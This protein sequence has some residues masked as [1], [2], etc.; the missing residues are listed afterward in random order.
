MEENSGASEKASAAVDKV[1]GGIK[2]GAKFLWSKIPLPLKLKILGGV[3]ALLLIILAVA[4]LVSYIDEI[5][6][7]DVREEVLNKAQ[8]QFKER[9]EKAYKEIQSNAGVK[10]DRAALASTILY[11]GDYD[12]LY[13][14]ENFG[15]EELLEGEGLNLFELGINNAIQF[16]DENFNTGIT[17]SGKELKKFRTSYKTIYNYGIAMINPDEKKLDLE[18]YK[19]NLEKSIV[20]KI[21]SDLLKKE[22][23]AYASA[24][25]AQE[26][27]D[28]A[29]VYRPWFED[30][31]KNSCSNGDSCTYEV[32]GKTVSNLKVRLLDKDGKP[33]ADEELVDFEKY[34]LGVTYAENYNGPGSPI[35]GLKAQAIAARGYSL[36]RARIMGGVGGIKLEEEN[37]EWIL[38]IRN[39]TGDQV[40]C[41]PDQGCSKPSGQ[42]MHGLTKTGVNLGGGYEEYKPPL[43]EESDLRQAFKETTGIVPLDT[44]GAV[45]YTQY[46]QKDQDAFN[47]MAKGGMEA[48]EIIIKHYANGY[49]GDTSETKLASSM[50]EPNCVGGSGS[51][52]TCSDGLSG[53]YGNFKEWKQGGTSP[54]KDDLIGSE[55]IGKVG[56]AATSV[57]IQLARSG[58][59]TGIDP[60]H[61]GTFVAKMKTVGGFMGNN[62]VWDAV[63]KFAPDFKMNNIYDLSG[64]AQAKAQFLGTKI[65]EG[66][67]LILAVKTNYGH[68]VAVDKVESGKI[69]IMDPGG[70]RTTVDEYASDFGWGAINRAV[71]YK[72]PSN[73]VN[74][75]LSN[76]FIN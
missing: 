23:G 1:A 35:E 46:R 21:Y 72:T 32:D 10:V 14:E 67:Y 19:E 57:A 24:R 41:D 45:L 63:Q 25:I 18:Y 52:G 60:L 48:T 16:L 30:D 7:K 50:S 75:T 42:K 22:Q 55:T 65:N 4:A 20:P 12:S 28:L 44:N 62:I 69:Y 64:D 40:Y 31:E 15:A 38:S 58:V 34:V 17:E 6:S 59:E 53:E 3:V 39:Y 70:P 61:P 54:W 29:D 47:S 68:W 56:C 5:Y 26:I 11:S 43:P 76:P 66:C 8:L 13:D 37:G 2:Q 27:I 71:C 51:S 73:K 36:T 9:I 74:I 33:M 49:W